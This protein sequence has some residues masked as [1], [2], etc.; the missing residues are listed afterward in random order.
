VVNY[1][2]DRE[3]NIPLKYFILVFQ[4]VIKNMNGKIILRLVEA[5]LGGNPDQVRMAAN[6]LSSDLY[7]SHP[8]LSR[9]IASASAS[10]GLRGAA[11]RVNPHLSKVSQS[12]Q[13]ELFKSDLPSFHIESPILAE[14]ICSVI[15]QVLNE[16]KLRKKLIE[17]NLEPVKTMIFM[18]PPGVGKTLSA[19]WVAQ[20]LGLPLVVLDLATVMSSQLGRTGNNLKS[21]IDHAAAE[22]CVLLL[23]EF[24]SIAKKRNDDSD[25]G[26]LKRLVTVLLQAIDSWPS[27][28]LLIAA[29]NHAELLDPAIWRRF[30]EK[31][32]FNNPDD[33]QIK[34]YL[35]SLTC[36]EKAAQLFPLFRGMSFSDIKTL[37]VRSK[38]ISLIDDIDLVDQLI[39]SCLFDRV[40]EGLSIKEKKEIAI[41]LIASKI[42]QR[43]V[44]KFLNMSRPTVSKVVSEQKTE[45]KAE[46]KAPVLKIIKAPHRNVYEQKKSNTL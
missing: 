34:D 15:Q 26:E 3:I 19:K 35:L 41:N 5:A 14:N 6:L 31:I 33:L 40:V 10:N 27:T 21:A 2:Y 11:E 23:D 45:K 7:N 22:P 44:A 42:S 8:E 24:D 28:S 29:T 16:H 20:E 17:N 32:I 30:E 38:K 4:M 43:Q 46:K 36:N 39:S 18:G 25:V 1:T 12:L 13:G 37:I 9:Q